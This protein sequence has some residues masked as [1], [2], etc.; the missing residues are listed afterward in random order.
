[1][2]WFYHV[3]SSSARRATN[4]SKN[5]KMMSN[6]EAA[7]QLRPTGASTRPPVVN[8]Y[9]P[10]LRPVAGAYCEDP[11]YR[12]IRHHGTDDHLVML[13]TGGAGFYQLAET[14]VELPP[15][16]VI[17]IRPNVPHDYGASGLTDAWEFTWVHFH[18][19]AEWAE[20]LVWTP[21]TRGVMVADLDS[22]ALVHARKTFSGLLD[23]P[24]PTTPLAHARLMHSLEAFLLEV[25]QSAGVAGRAPTDARVLRVQRLMVQ[26]LDQPHTLSSLADYV[27]LSPSRLAHRFSEAVGMAPMKHLESLRLD[28][29]RQLLSVTDAPVAEVA[30][31]TGF[32]NAFHF[33]TRFRKRFGFPPREFRAG[34]R[35]G[36]KSLNESVA[37]PLF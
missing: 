16:R 29:A 28:R 36:P 25:T 6:P 27:G 23:Q 17:L 12:L 4:F 35:A 32:P 21:A 20:W 34:Q 10:S 14:R 2:I 37:K 9:H 19:R 1:M 13:T 26:Q 7:V 24:S 18:P 15:G 11:G 3:P 30:R 31:R 5:R 8:P 33:A 22:D